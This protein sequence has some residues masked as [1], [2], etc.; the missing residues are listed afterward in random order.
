MR[1]SH[2]SYAELTKLILNTFIVFGV[3]GISNTTSAQEQVLHITNF[4]HFGPMEKAATSKLESAYQKLN[5]RMELIKYPGKRALI[6]S[7][8]GRS[9]GELVR[10]A[11]LSQEYENLI[12]IPTPIVYTN[13]IALA[14]DDK[15]KLEKG[16]ESVRNYSFAYERGTKL[17]EDYT[18]GFSKG[19]PQTDIRLSF[20]LLLSRQIDLI[21]INEDAGLQLMQEL[22]LQQSVHQ[23]SPILSRTPLYHYLHKKHRDLATKLDTVLKS[24]N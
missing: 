12:Q 6:E 3:F 9:D 11:G 16:W 8:E 18:H 19:L 4:A 20:R 17:I 22:G 13:T 14:V 2:F 24:A 7:N 10:K 5:V 23:I 1:Q 21:I 15:I